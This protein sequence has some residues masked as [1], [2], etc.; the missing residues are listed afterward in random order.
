[1]VLA[2]VDTK[3]WGGG[4]AGACVTLALTSVVLFFPPSPPNFS[5]GGLFRDEREKEGRRFPPI[6]RRFPPPEP[7]PGVHC[8]DHDVAKI[9]VSAVA[10]AVACSFRAC[11]LYWSHLHVNVLLHS[12]TGKDEK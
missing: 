4:V 11:C 10:L 8:S 9:G 6:L 1:M 5:S 7:S 3:R 2:L 12:H